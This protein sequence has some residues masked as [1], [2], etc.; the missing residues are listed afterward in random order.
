MVEVWWKLGRVKSVSDYKPS[1]LICQRQ[2]HILLKEY[3]KASP[4]KTDI[5]KVR[6]DLFL[7]SVKSPLQMHIRLPCSTQHSP[8]LWSLPS[9]CQM[10]KENLLKGLFTIFFLSF[11][12]HI[13]DSNGTK[14]AI[15]HPITIQNT[16]LIIVT[17]TMGG[18]RVKIFCQV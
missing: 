15:P 6:E 13:L 8:H 4:C 1:S 11:K 14:S 18:A 12:S 17:G 16:Y 3:C 5:L 10:Q 7:K 9:S 2:T